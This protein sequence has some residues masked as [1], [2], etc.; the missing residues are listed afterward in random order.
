MAVEKGYKRIALIN[1]P[2]QRGASKERLNGYID[3]HAQ[4][5][6]KVNM[7]L[8]ERTDFSKVG[9]HGIMR[10]LLDLRVHP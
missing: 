6:L 7:H 3:G 2:D 4:K 9:T 10:K 5:K 8:I 1:G